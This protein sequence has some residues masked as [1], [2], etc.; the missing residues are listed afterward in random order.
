MKINSK[1]IILSIILF[2]I[3]GLQI[4]K[5]KGELIN[6]FASI[7]IQDQIETEVMFDGDLTLSLDMLSINYSGDRSKLQLEVQAGNGYALSGKTISP[8]IQYAEDWEAKG[9]EIIVNLQVT[10]GVD[11]SQ[12]FPFKVLVIPPILPLAYS[13]NSCKGIISLTLSAYKPNQRHEESFPFT[14]KLI[15]DL[16]DTLR[17]VTVNNTA[18]FQS[19]ATATF[20]QDYELNRDIEYQIYAIDNLGREYLRDSG[21]LGQAYSLDF[22]LNFAG[23]LCPEDQTGLVEFIIFN[24]TLPVNNFI[25]IDSEGKQKQTDFEIVSDSDGFI[26]I[27]AK[28]LEPGTYTI[29]IEDRFQCNGSES[30]EIV[31]PEPMDEVETVKHVTCFGNNDGEISLI[32]DGGW[33]SPFPKSHRNEWANYEVTWFDD[34]ENEVKTVNNSFVSLAG[35]IIGMESKINNLPP[36]DYYAKIK[37]KGRLFDITGAAPLVCEKTTGWITIEGPEPLTLSETIENI[38]CN[39]MADGS[40]SINPL[41]G[42]PEYTIEWFKGNFANL[43]SPEPGELTS[44][45]LNS[46][47]SELSRQHLDPGEYAVLI[48]DQNGCIVANNYTINE[49]T[50]LILKEL[51][52]LRQ[53]V[54]CFGE[55]AGTIAIQLYENTPTPFSIEVFRNGSTFKSIGPINKVDS[56]TLYFQI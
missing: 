53:D 21:P 8:S 55:E 43:N 6:P 45:P 47:E 28:D 18:P 7:T 39:G 32:I 33:S 25:V 22:E 26:V 14:F 40:I 23:L 17:V 54:R 49:P 34:K 52:E 41:G 15:D 9:K 24:A 31:I 30:F 1:Y 42:S 4:F 38:S 46:E 2:L 16:G 35:T 19:S 3:F 51:S 56:D 36:G 11:H 10:D 5:I 12:V 48:T 37:D 50:P 20:G 29:E 44:F 13:E 27:Q